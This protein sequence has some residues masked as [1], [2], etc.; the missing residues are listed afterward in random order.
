LTEFFLSLFLRCRSM[1]E[2]TSVVSVVRKLFIL[3]RSALRIWRFARPQGVEKE[4]GKPGQERQNQALRR[5]AKSA[6]PS[7]KPRQAWGLT[8]LI[9]MQRERLCKFLWWW[10]MELNPEPLF[11]PMRKHDGISALTAEHKVAAASG[12]ACACHPDHAQ[13]RLRYPL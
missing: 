10:N 5:A 4:R 6:S 7:E 2:K 3:P 11:Q 1:L 13:S 8:G 12:E 9:E